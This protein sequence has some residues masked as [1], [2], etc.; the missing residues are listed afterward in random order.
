[1]K[2]RP[3]VD[4][5]LDVL[6][7]VPPFA[8]R[9]GRKPQAGGILAN[10]HPAPV[11]SF[12][13]HRP[14]RLERTR[15][16]VRAHGIARS[17][18]PL[19]TLPLLPALLSPTRILQGFRMF[20]GF[21]LADQMLHPAFERLGRQPV[22]A[23]I[24]RAR[25]SALTPCLDVQRP[26]RAVRFYPGPRCHRR[27]SHV[28]ENPIWNDT[29]LSESRAR[30]GRLPPV[31]GRQDKANFRSRLPPVARGCLHIVFCSV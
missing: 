6:D 29:A 9:V 30:F 3:P 25:H 14:E 22:L 5:H 28:R 8:L 17:L 26:I 31:G 2:M 12:H 19:A 11:H 15:A 24:I 23:A 4:L 20:A 16:G 21:F 10:T 13:M 27:S 1:M 7:T 18:R